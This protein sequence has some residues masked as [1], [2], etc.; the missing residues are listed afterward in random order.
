MSWKQLVSAVLAAV[1]TLS[2]ALSHDALADDTAQLES[3]NRRRESADWRPAALRERRVRRRSDSRVAR[4][5]VRQWAGG[6]CARS[7]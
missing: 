3:E 7:S 1:P 6:A 4:S 2:H 5:P